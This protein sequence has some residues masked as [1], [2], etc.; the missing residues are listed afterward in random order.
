MEERALGYMQTGE[1][2]SGFEVH[3]GMKISVW[4]L[5]VTIREVTWISCARALFMFS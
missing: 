1:E 3:R 4:G 2:A 5:I